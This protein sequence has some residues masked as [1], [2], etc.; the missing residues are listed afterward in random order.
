MGAVVALLAVSA[1]CSG[2]PTGSDGG[3]QSSPA[4]DSVPAG[5]DVVGYVDVQGALGDDAVRTV[6]NESIALSSR[7]SMDEDAPDTLAA[8]IAEAENESELDLSA[9]ASVTFYGRTNTTGDASYSAAVLSTGWA[10]SDL[11]A[12]MENDST[13]SLEETT[14][15]GQ[16][17][18]EP[19]GG[20]ET[21]VAGEDLGSWVGVL[22]DGSYVVGSESAVKDALDV[23]A[24]NA[25]RLSGDLRTAFE[26]T[27][28][29]YL[30]YAVAVPQEEFDAGQV[31]PG[32]NTDVFNDVTLVSGSL[33]TE[34]E[35]I[36]LETTL[37]FQSD[38]AAGDAR[39]VLKG[40]V[41]TYRGLVEDNQ[42]K[43]LLSEEHLTVEADGSTVVVTSTNSADDVVSILEKL[44]GSPMAGPGV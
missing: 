29:G 21:V 39:D 9:F 5:A 43:Q 1:G 30:R 42:T 41:T 18:Y 32:M 19:T 44:Y 3:V 37:T 11:V 6:L 35:D 16:T 2:L 15:E 12:A 20:S 10:E 33:Y 14:Y 8:A 17:L 25:D 34:G 22:G 26:D 4:L 7:S 27:G 24:G 38:S 31:S 40:A 28:D 36:S 23:S 13:Y